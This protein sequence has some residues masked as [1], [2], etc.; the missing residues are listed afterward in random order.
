MYVLNSVRVLEHPIFGFTF[1]LLYI[2]HVTF[3]GMA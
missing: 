3:M 1:E 2:V